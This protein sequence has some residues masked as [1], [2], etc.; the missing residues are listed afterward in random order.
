[1][2]ERRDV[3]A[4]YE[5]IASHFSE[6]REYAWPEVEAFLD[7]R[8]GRRGLDVGCG[9][10]RHTERLAD[11]VTHA[12]GLDASRGLLD[13]ARARLAAAD[14]ADRTSLLHGDAAALPLRDDAADL[15]VYVATLHHLPTRTARLASLDE[16]A[17]VLTP[18][19]TALVS[20]WSTAHDTFDETESFDTTVDW[21]LPGGDTV[22]RYYHIY[23]PDDFRT[24][25]ADSDLHLSDLE[26]SSGNCY[27][28]VTPE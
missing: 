5:E 28:T 27:A 23:S 24:D 11:C 14:L 2:T 7:G 16:L 25:L 3:R 15:A 18:D 21:T 13:E 12:V 10:G 1:M 9:N 17:R 4:T 19:A 20:V 22:P 8:R 6:T 26:L